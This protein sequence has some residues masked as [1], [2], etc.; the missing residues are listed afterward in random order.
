MSQSSQ[1]YKYVY[2]TRTTPPRHRNLLKHTQHTL[3]DQPSTETRAA[4]WIVSEA[5]FDTVETELRPENKLKASKVSEESA[6]YPP[7][8]RR[9]I[10]ST[11]QLTHPASIL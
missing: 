5:G 7:I 4:S 9:D 8:F 10:P 3:N 2:R 1:E 6:S 11:F